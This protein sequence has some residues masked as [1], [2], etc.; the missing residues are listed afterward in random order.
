MS[1]NLVTFPSDHSSYVS[2]SKDKT[3][4]YPGSI[5]VS[6]EQGRVFI[7]F[8]DGSVKLDKQVSNKFFPYSTMIDWVNFVEKIEV[9]LEFFFNIFNWSDNFTEHDSAMISN[10]RVSD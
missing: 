7:L 9:S 8:E 3:I 2:S 4:R 5:Q 10:S 6:N 1:S